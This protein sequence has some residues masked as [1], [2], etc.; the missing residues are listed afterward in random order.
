MSVASSAAAPSSD[1]V[2]FLPYLSGERTPH[3]D[4]HAKG[5]FFGLTLRHTKAHL[6]RAVLEGIVFGLRDSLELMRAQGMSFDQVRLSG[7]GAQS[8]LWRQILADVFDTE[9]VTARVTEGAA[10]GAA[11]L[12]MPERP[13]PEV[14]EPILP[15]P[16][17]EGYLETYRRYRALY[18]ALAERFRDE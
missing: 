10:Y 13:E 17:V 18:P 11:L 4:P 16:D 15:G 14:S 6:T 12:A 8:A 9:I 5:V 3:P 7:G 2:I 1:G